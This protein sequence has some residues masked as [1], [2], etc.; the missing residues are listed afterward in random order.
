MKHKQHITGLIDEAM[1]ELTSGVSSAALVLAGLHY[2]R[3][4]GTERYHVE[5][6]AV[7]SPWSFL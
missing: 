5:E 4:R 1:R 2:Y 6:R 7:F 3:M